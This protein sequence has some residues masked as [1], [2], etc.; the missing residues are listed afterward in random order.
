[1]FTQVPQKEQPE[2]Q[3]AWGSLFGEVASD[4]RVGGQERVKQGQQEEG[5]FIEA[6]S[7]CSPLS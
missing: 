6:L 2:A 5:H 3:A 7:P 4:V 1:M